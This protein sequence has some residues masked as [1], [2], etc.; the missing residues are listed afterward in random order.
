MKIIRSLMAVF[1]SLISFNVNSID[2]K[3]SVKVINMNAKESLSLINANKNNNNFVILDVRTKDEYSSGHIENALNIDYYL[4]DFKDELKK[5]DKSKKYFIYC[6]SGH[7]SGETGKIMVDLGFKDI[8]NLSGG[9]STL[10]SE[11]YKLVK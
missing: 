2:S 10:T 11:G 3:N 4:P 8:T 1:L 6:R 7:R 9:I 5:L